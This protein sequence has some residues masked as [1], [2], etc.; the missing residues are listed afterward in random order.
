MS[1]KAWVLYLVIILLVRSGDASILDWVWGVSQENAGPRPKIGDAPIVKVPFEVT[2]ED[3][4]FL[5]AAKEYTS[6]KLSDL[7]TCQHVVSKSS[8]MR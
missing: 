4:Q 7:D 8:L 5:E 3:Q 1:S 2:T 6:L